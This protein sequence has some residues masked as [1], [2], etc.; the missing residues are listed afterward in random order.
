MGRKISVW[1]LCRCIGGS[2][3]FTCVCACI[4]LP[5]CLLRSTWD[6]IATSGSY[7]WGPANY[8]LQTLQTNS[9]QVRHF[10]LLCF[11]NWSYRFFILKKYKTKH[12]VNS[13]YLSVLIISSVWFSSSISHN[14]VQL[15]RSF[16]VL[17]NCKL[18][19]VLTSHS[20]FLNTIEWNSG[21][22]S[23]VKRKHL[24]MRK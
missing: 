3:T 6:C 10:S 14:C 19:T 18:T 4:W 15:W 8:F 7:Q 11:M 2:D 9:C 13:C 20:C 1:E 21:M 16:T 24:T 17:A 23:V 12:N 5:R 22:Y